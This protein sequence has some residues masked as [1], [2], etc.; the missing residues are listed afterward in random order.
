MLGDA[1]EETGQRLGLIIPV[2]LQVCGTVLMR[3]LPSTVWVYRR[4]F[5]VAWD[6]RKSPFRRSYNNQARWLLERWLD[7]IALAA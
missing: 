4:S 3:C 5:A 6:N 2:R 7:G 1:F